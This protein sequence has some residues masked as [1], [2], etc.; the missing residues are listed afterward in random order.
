MNPNRAAPAATKSSS[1]KRQVNIPKGQQQKATNQPTSAAGRPKQTYSARPGGNSKLQHNSPPSSS[2]S[3]SQQWQQ[4]SLPTIIN[5]PTSLTNLAQ[6][7]GITLLP[8]GKIHQPDTNQRSQQPSFSTSNFPTI[9]NGLLPTNFNNNSTGVQSQRQRPSI[10]RSNNTVGQPQQSI[11]NLASIPSI[12]LLNQHTTTPISSNDSSSLSWSRNACANDLTSSNQS[13]L[14]GLMQ[15]RTTPKSSGRTNNRKTKASQDT[16]NLANSFFNDIQVLPVTDGPPTTTDLADMQPTQSGSSFDDILS[17]PSLESID[18]H[19]VDANGDMNN[20]SLIKLMAILNNPALTIT[21]VGNSKSTNNNKPPPPYGFSSS[22]VDDNQPVSSINLLDNQQ[23]SISLASNQPTRS[24]INQ[25]KR[26]YISHATGNR[27]DQPL[28]PE[29]AMNKIRI[30]Q[31]AAN[32]QVMQG[33]DITDCIS[34]VQ[35]REVNQVPCGSSYIAENKESQSTPINKPSDLQLNWLSNYN[36]SGQTSTNNQSALWVSGSLKTSSKNEDNFYM[37]DRPSDPTMLS[38]SVRNL[39]MQQLPQG[40]RNSNVSAQLLKHIANQT[41]DN[42]CHAISQSQKSVLEPECIL[43]VPRNVQHLGLGAKRIETSRTVSIIAPLVQKKEIKQPL[44]TTK[45]RL[46]VPR[47]QNDNSRTTRV[48]TQFELSSINIEVSGEREVHVSEQHEMLE[49]MMSSAN[50]PSLKSAM[51]EPDEIFINRSKRVMSKIDTML[52]RKK[53]RRFERISGRAAPKTNSLDDQC[54]ESENEW[55][56]DENMDVDCVDFIKTQLPLKE[57]E[58]DEKRNHLMSVGLVSRYNRN[59]LLVRQYE[60]KLNTISPLALEDPKEVSQDIQRFVDIMLKTGGTDI[61]MRVDSTIKRNDLPLIEGLNRNT[62]RMKMSYMNVLGLE[63]RSKRTTLYKVKQ[64]EN[65]QSNIPTTRPINDLSKVN[66]P[67]EL[68]KDSELEATS[69][70]TTTFD[71][72]IVRNN[73]LPTRHTFTSSCRDAMKP[74]NKNEYMK[75]L[76]L[77]AS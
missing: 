61:Q 35:R 11:F 17:Q 60:E 48:G 33:G 62:S 30:P 10:N 22:T 59:K 64:T 14:K 28:Q 6:L 31:S 51:H 20:I 58:T 71:Q 69:K 5:A 13:Q 38:T 12:Q 37:H 74:P 56:G 40:A 76:G 54:I 42:S 43:S 19:C 65:V 1:N 66:K 68:K 21:A 44:R 25:P 47:S 7:S 36:S 29:P 34:T 32:L 27:H 50:K 67:V 41:K 57:L 75:S 26:D 16:I 63:K 73:I 2:S 23:I 3:S 24:Y 46:Y 77:M 52:E 70:A 53:R 9:I 4:S 8:M 15:S 18:E 55:S 39:M 49:S 45:N 72:A